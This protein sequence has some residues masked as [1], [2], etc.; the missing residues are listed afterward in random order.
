[1][2]SGLTD[3]LVCC[4]INCMLYENEKI[5]IIDND[6]KNYKFIGDNSDLSDELLEISEGSEDEISPDQVDEEEW[7]DDSVARRIS[8]ERKLNNDL[9]RK[10]F[11]DRG[12]EWIV[13]G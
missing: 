2:I 7:Q 12:L 4:V 11:E 13:A 6:N 8:F 5:D 3:I 9:N 10:S 1:M